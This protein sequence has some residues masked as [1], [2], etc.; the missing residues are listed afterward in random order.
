LPFHAQID[1]SYENYRSTLPSPYA[2]VEM[3]CPNSQGQ[4]RHFSPRPR[5]RLSPSQER[6]QHRDPPLDPTCQCRPPTP[7]TSHTLWAHQPLSLKKKEKR[8]KNG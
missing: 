8:K 6:Q 5:S 2:A 1:I 3:A 4:T 7:T